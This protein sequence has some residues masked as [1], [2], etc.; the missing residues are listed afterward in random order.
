MVDQLLHSMPWVFLLA[1][2]IGLAF[3]INAFRSVRAIMPLIAHSFFAGWLTAELALHH[4][5]W[6]VAATLVFVWAG[7]L[8]AAPG[9]I[10]LGLSL[11]SWAGLTLLHIEAGR[12]AKHMEDALGSAF[13][14]TYRE[15]LGVPV[16]AKLPRGRLVV[17]FWLTDPAVRVIKNVRYAP[18]G[19]Q[20][21]LLDIYL[22]KQ[23]VQNAPVLLQI[24]GGAWIIGDKAQ[25]ARPLLHYM[26]ARGFICVSINYRLSPR[27]QWPDHLVDVKHALAWVKQHIAELGGDPNFVIATGGSAGGY[28]TAMLALTANEPRFQPG[29]DEVDTSLQGAVPF[30]A[31]YDLLDRE[32]MQR[33]MGLRLLLEYVVIR[34]SRREAEEIYRD[35][36]PLTHVREDAP[37]FMIVHGTH[38]SLTPVEEARLF[39]QRLRAVSRNAV[40]YVEL[41][42][43]QHAFEVFHS[44]RTLHAIQGVHRFAVAVH[45]SYLL[46]RTT[47]TAALSAAVEPALLQQHLG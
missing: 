39:V 9:W 46:Q 7:A 44:V 1:S 33:N 15:S 37:P 10:A 23:A 16:D 24:H 36:S 6:Q 13:G 41:P 31:P 11:I 34:K 45:S 38:D 29:F 42:Y 5:A 3:T 40:V 35:A 19:G 28:L 4:L 12:T 27:A 47:N 18:G 2:L 43:A 14:P 30:Y 32:A 17:P 26:A 8:S 22:P 20:R 25:Q 21:R